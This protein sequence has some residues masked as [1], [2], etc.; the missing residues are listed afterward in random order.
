MSF[1]SVPCVSCRVAASIAARFPCVAAGATSVVRSEWTN[2]WELLRSWLAYRVQ[3][4]VG[5]LFCVL[6]D[7]ILGRPLITTCVRQQPPPAR[8]RRLASDGALRRTGCVGVPLN[9]IQ[10]Q[11]G[12][13]Y[14]I[15]SV[16]LQGIDNA[17]IIDTVPAHRPPM[18][19]A[20][21]GLRQPG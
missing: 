10:R 1:A 7:R 4:P 17:E 5:R 13:I 18:I 2:G 21:A 8:L 6:D 12:P 15:T 20:T 19:P 11:L 14:G 16:Y 3:I 9:V